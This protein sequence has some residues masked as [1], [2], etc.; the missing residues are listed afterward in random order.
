MLQPEPQ[1]RGTWVYDDGIWLVRHHVQRAGDRLSLAA[2]SEILLG[3]GGYY[4]HFRWVSWNS[5]G[6]MIHLVSSYS[7]HLCTHCWRCP[8]QWKGSSIQ[9]YQ[10]HGM[11]SQR[12]EKM[13]AHEFTRTLSQEPAQSFIMWKL[14]MH[15]NS[16]HSIWDICS[17][18]IVLGIS[19]HS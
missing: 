4:R 3:G 19:Q 6:F 17:V 12:W 13:F 15:R 9:L 16:R 5:R 1:T 14:E 10:R 8:Q 2:A 11:R 7:L 18:Y